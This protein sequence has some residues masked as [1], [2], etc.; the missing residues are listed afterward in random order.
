MTFDPSRIAD[1]TYF[2]ENRR[3]AHS[4]H[5]WFRD[6]AE[7]RAGSS[8]FEQSLNG[9]WKFH[10]A[11][12]QSQVVAGFFEPGH[13][14]SGWDDIPVP[15]HMQLEGYG[16]P[17]YV[18][19][20]YAWDGQEDIR[21][22][23][24]PVRDNPVG[25][26]VR[27][28]V[29]DQPL[30]AGERLSVTFHGAES[31]IAVWLNGRYLGY[32]TDSFTP[33]EFD[34]TDALVE[35]E[36]LLAAQV[37]SFSGGSWLE[38]QDA[39]RF[40]GIFRDVVL[41]RRPRAHV[42]DL[43]VRTVVAQD[44]ASAEVILDVTLDGD[45]AVSAWIE[46]IE[47]AL[48]D[49][50]DGA[51]AVRVDAPRLWSP[52]SPHLYDLVIEVRDAAGAVAEVITQR[53]GIRRFGIENGV[54]SLNGRRVVFN[55]INR[56]EFGLNGRVASRELAEAD[57]RAMKAVGINAVRTSHY[58]N[59]SAFYALADEYGLL[60]V[61]EM[62]VE[63]HGVWARIAEQGAPVESAVPGDDPL[64]RDAVLDRARSM[65]ERDKNHASVVIW[66][67]GN[68]AFG[69]S[70][71]RDV[72][73]WF[74]AVD[75]RPVH[76]EGV[77]AD[78]RYPE[79]TDITSQMYTSPAA[80]EEHLRTHRDKPFLLCEYAHAMGNSFGGIGE[81]VDLAYR[82][83]LFQGG[84]VWDFADQAIAM[85]D[86]YGK[87]Y[88]GY[89][90]DNDEAVHDHDFSGNGIFFADHSPSPKAQELKRLYQGFVVEVSGEEFTLSNRLLFTSSAA[91]ET[92]VSVARDGL[93]VRSDV[94]ETDV[95]PGG[96]QTFPLPAPV[97]GAAPGVAPGTAPTAA[98]EYAI[99]VSL[100]L[101][102]AT[103][104]APAG[105]E[106]AWGEHVRT[107]GAPPARVT[108]PPPQVVEGVRYIGV[109]GDG[110]HVM[111]SRLF[112]GLRSYRF[113]Q[114]ASGG[115][116]LLAG[117]VTPNFWHAPTANQRGW[118]GPFDEGPWLLASRYG[119]A[120]RFH[121]PADISV[122][123]EARGVRIGFRYELPTSPAAVCD[124]GYLVDGSGR[125]E[126]TQTMTVPDGLPE[127]PEFATMI[128][129][130]ADYDRVRWYGEGPEECYVDRREGARLGLYERS[131]GDMLTPYLR[132]QE[133]GNRTGVRWAEVTDARGAGLRFEGDPT[134]EF[135]ALHFTP[136][137][138]ED[139][140][141]PNELPPVHRT[142]VRPALMRRGVGGD[143]SWG[144]RPLERYRL[145]AGRLE[146][147]FAFR[148]V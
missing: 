116:E 130:P 125:V 47:G 65:L 32:A 148:G 89:G 141:H 91:Y 139:A 45:G 77:Y 112:N 59:D 122:A 132:P 143:D 144:A 93:L 37:F 92:R 70:V 16:R 136:T 127:L 110:F 138:I 44:L 48:V 62:N 109:H 104:W 25:S 3:P 9:R 55:G 28:F 30:Q 131:V 68:E 34:L 38:D 4:D 126:V 52:E 105:F 69:G 43:R 71:F 49:R 41:Y 11:K 60:V 98:G 87:Q 129:M 23:E 114:T 22:G 108:P 100:H 24:V 17:Q 74:R 8:F 117:A 35:G 40:S 42:E 140:R 64:W 57:I 5:R 15:S 101:R 36:N 119:R 84:F 106:I 95:E 10:Y 123:T 31:A 90:G 73:E 103:R 81:Y 26:Y 97:P 137:E 96:S 27:T 83:E 50:G 18:N 33:S 7:A 145:P 61:D 86:R 46:G 51:L 99:V 21:P 54:L 63:T 79:T 113:G 147:R 121:E 53:I 88:F 134:M 14:V 12:N 20:G 66:S 39:F 75:D 135:S 58:P 6:L 76:Y 72:A 102:A 118:N 13:D 124:L 67:C 80:V 146:F 94:V 1:P 56:H 115:R 120:S 78:P 2:S 133:A 19:V 82:D 107:V 29:L 128:A 85:R 111:F 142:I